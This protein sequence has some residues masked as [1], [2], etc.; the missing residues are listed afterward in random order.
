MYHIVYYCTCYPHLVRSVGITSI[1]ILVL[2]MYILLCVLLQLH[3]VGV[4]LTMVDVRSFAFRF[5]TLMVMELKLSVTVL[6]E[7]SSMAITA[8]VINV[9]ALQLM[10]GFLHCADVYRALILNVYYV[11]ACTCL[12]ASGICITVILSSVSSVNCDVLF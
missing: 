8:H 2:Y 9:S 11:H 6:L 1:H 7:L 10:W 3:P 4:L 5:P 12:V